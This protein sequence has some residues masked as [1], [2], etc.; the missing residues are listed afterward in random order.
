MTVRS[1]GVRL[2]VGAVRK[3]RSCAGDSWLFRSR[4][5]AVEKARRQAAKTVL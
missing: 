1:D 2:S 3:C 5:P 4:M